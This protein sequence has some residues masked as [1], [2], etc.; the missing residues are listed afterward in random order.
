[1]CS[2]SQDRVY[3]D[4]IRKVLTIIE[5]KL[6]FSQHFMDFYINYPCLLPKDHL[7]A[8]HDP[9]KHSLQLTSRKIVSVSLYMPIKR[10]TKAPKQP[11]LLSR[12]S[13]FA[14]C[15]SFY[16]PKRLE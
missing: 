12:G 11:K 15:S 1:M 5:H 6:F 8:M 10:A 16:L 9:L 4:V 2:S 3:T 13:I 14:L 7:E